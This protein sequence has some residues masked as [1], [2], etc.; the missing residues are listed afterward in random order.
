MTFGKNFYSRLKKR[1]QY[2]QTGKKF[3][4]GFIFNFISIM[5]RFIAINFKR[6]VNLLNQNKPR[7]L[8]RKSHF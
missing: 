5:V 3:A 1:C 7:H 8:V 6:S 2:I 4:S